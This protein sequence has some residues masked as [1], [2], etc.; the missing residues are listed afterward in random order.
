[1]TA[2]EKILALI[3]PEYLERVPRMFRGHATKTT[4]KKKIAQEY[5]DLYAKSEVA[6]DLPDEATQELSIIINGI[7]EV[8]I[9]KHNF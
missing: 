9:K 4:V 6:G 2:D 8:K 1:M 7:F 3:K 5:L